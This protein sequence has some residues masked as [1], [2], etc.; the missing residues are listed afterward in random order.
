MDKKGKIKVKIEVA[1]NKEAM[2]E[3]VLTQ[4]LKF[5]AFLKNSVK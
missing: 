1:F 4:A 5:I 3:R 2:K